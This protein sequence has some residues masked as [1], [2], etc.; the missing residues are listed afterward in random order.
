MCRISLPPN[1]LEPL[2]PPAGCGSPTIPDMRN[3]LVRKAIAPL[4]SV[5]AASIVAPEAIAAMRSLGLEGQQGYFGVRTAALGV[6]PLE[7]V[8]A[9]FYGHS[10]AFI[11]SAGEGVW[12]KTSPPELLRAISESLHHSLGPVVVTLG[13]PAEELTA[14]LR[15]AAE[16]ASQRPEGR[17]L[18]AANASLPWPDEV[19]LQLWHAHVLLREWRG[20]GHNAL[21]I[22]AGLSGLDGLLVHAA[23]AGLP[24]TAIA[25]SRQWTA[26]DCAPAIAELQ[27]RG[28]LTH[29]E[30]ATITDEGRRRR[31]AIEDATD[32]A[33]Q[34][35]YGAFSDEELSRLVGLAAQVGE[36][37][38]A[39]VVRP[40]G[41]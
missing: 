38:A 30:P 19:H 9:V 6:V 35:A 12:E 36:A 7:V 20:D 32:E 1:S 25:A 27:S 22:G 15:E 28:W 40:A 31:D 2:L 4:R 21:L 39:G 29:G 13:K 8:Q 24:L 34:F 5:Y 16:R 23:W 33:D 10:P 17:A 26:D 37:V 3:Q 18:F 14:M 11:L 41:A